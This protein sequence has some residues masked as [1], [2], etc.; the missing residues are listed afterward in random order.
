M[1]L[2]EGELAALLEE[3]LAK[4]LGY[5]APREVGRR[6]GMRSDGSGRVVLIL[7]R[8]EILNMNEP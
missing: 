8:S 1:E 7:L 3:M 6:L 4:C 5:A 2:A